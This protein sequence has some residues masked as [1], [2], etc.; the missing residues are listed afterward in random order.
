ME[1]IR[2]NHMIV[3]FLWKEFLEDYD[4]FKIEYGNIDFDNITSIYCKLEGLCPNSAICAFDKMAKNAQ[5]GEPSKHRIFLFASSKK[6]KVTMAQLQECLKKVNVKIKQITY[7]PAYNEGIYTYNMLNLLLSMIPNRNKTLSYAHGKLICGTCSSIYNKGRSAG[8][9]LGLHISFDYDNLLT[10][11][12]LTFAEEDKVEKKNKKDSPVYHLEFDEKR[13]YFSSKKKKGTKEYYH[14]PSVFRKDNKNHIPFL[15]FCDIEHFEESQAYLIRSVLQDFLTT[16][17]KYV[18]VNPIEYKKPTLLKAQDAEFR[19]EDE[20]LRDMLYT[21]W[22]EIACH[23]TETGVEELRNLIEKKSREYI[24]KLFG[25][26][27]EGCYEKDKSRK[28]ICIRIVGDKDQEGK[29]SDSEHKTLDYRRLKEKMELMEK[30]IP[31]QDVMIKSEIEAATIKNIFRQILIKDYCIKEALPQYMTDRFKG[32]VITYA[33]KKKNGL[34]YFVQLAIGKDGSITYKVGEPRL[35]HDKVITV[36]GENFESYEYHIPAFNKGYNENFIYCIE[37]DGITYNIYDTCEFVFPEME[38]IHRSL[39][40]LRNVQ[41]PVE[42]YKDLMDKVQSNESKTL[43]KQRICEYADNVPH[44]LFYSDIKK[45]GKEAPSEK[46]LT[47][48]LMRFVTSKY[49]IKKG[50]DF[51]TAG[52]SE[53]TLAAC[54]NVHYWKQDTKLWKY[55]AGPNTKG[56]FHCINHK[57]YVRELVSDTTPNEAFVNELIYSLGDGWNK[58]NEFSVHPSIFKFLKERLE[59]YKVQEQLNELTKKVK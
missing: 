55:C 38:E 5:S 18:S 25:N 15:G 27:F 20:L 33:E 29:L 26:S 42:V 51:R 49:N 6:E 28:Q 43:C 52:R 2:T 46:K 58:I 40:E 11:R 24:K 8:E 14:H 3:Q 53:E 48:K 47:L 56:K 41:V 4:F 36:M 22:I 50:Q 12:T 17:S 31:T 45:L 19:K 10:A 39:V 23:T 44:D 9:E 37:K 21:S 16:C 57:V 34:Y 7:C 32:C 59:V 13:I 35:P 54:A 30:K 1:K